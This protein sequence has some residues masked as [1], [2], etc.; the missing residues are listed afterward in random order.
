MARCVG[1]STRR[2]KRRQRS[3]SLNRARVQRWRNLRKRRVEQT[4]CPLHFDACRIDPR[5]ASHS[6]G[7]GARL[8]LSVISTSQGGVRRRV[9]GGD[10][11]P[12][13]TFGKKHGS[14]Q[15][16]SQGCD[17]SSA[18][19]SSPI[20]VVDGGSWTSNSTIQ[21]FEIPDIRAYIAQIDDNACCRC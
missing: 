16:D 14:A 2:R 21:C 5:E 15:L 17:E 12:T 8:M 6:L 4:G 9:G 1:F 11:Y 3:A 18:C 13:R 10:C 7:G 20:G 19:C